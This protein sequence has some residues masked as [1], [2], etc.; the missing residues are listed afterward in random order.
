MPRLSLAEQPDF[1][2]IS[3]EIAKQHEQSVKRLQDWIHQPSIAAENRGMAEGCQMMKDPVRDAGF[4]SVTK[5]PTDGHPGV[6]ATLDAGAPHT[7]GLYF[8]YDVKQVDPAEWSS[9]PWDAAI[10]DKSGLGKVVVGRTMPTANGSTLA[11]AP[12]HL[13]GAPRVVSVPSS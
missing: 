2:T 9:P 8:I 13:L 12:Q 10:V 6:F 3:A 11:Y 1:N 4:T 7:L 5:V